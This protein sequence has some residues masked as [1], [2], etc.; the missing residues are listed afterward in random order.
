MRK[1]FL[2]FYCLP[3]ME[4]LVWILLATLIYLFLY[5]RFKNSPVWKSCNL[6]FLTC[7]I[8][9][10]LLGTLVQRTAGHSPS[11][12]VLTPFYSYYLARHG[13]SPEIY[14]TNFMNTVFFYP[15]GLL[16]SAILPGAWP[17]FRKILLLTVFFAMLSI[18]I[19]FIQYSF[20][21]GIA[22]VDDVIHNALGTLLGTL[23]FSLLAK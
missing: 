1:I 22:E 10:I 23:V 18:G 5:N 2:W 20:G 17:R 11:D 3:I 19:E 21:L 6:I 16:A 8:G 15:A 12:P 7:W 4:A 13:G 9:A 14:R